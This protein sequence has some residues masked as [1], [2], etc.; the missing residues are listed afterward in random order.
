MCVKVC[1]NV[2]VQVRVH[3]IRA[4]GIRWVSV[5]RGEEGIGSTYFY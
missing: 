3:A 2:C 1:V 5:A 4:S